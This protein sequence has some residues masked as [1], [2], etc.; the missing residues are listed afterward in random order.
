MKYGLLILFLFVAVFPGRATEAPDAREH[1]TAAERY[2]QQG[3]F[4]SALEEYRLALELGLDGPGV[5]QRLSIL[6]YQQGFV[7]QAIAAMEQAVAFEPETDYLHQQLGLLYFAAAK[8]EQAR[9]EFL[10]SLK[11]NPA[12]AES[13]FYLAHLLGREGKMA[14][15][16]LF[17]RSA[18]QLGHPSRDLSALIEQEDKSSVRNLWQDDQGRLY[19]RKIFVADRSHADQILSRIAAGEPFESFPRDGAPGNNPKRGG[20]A[21]GF[22]PAELHPQIVD[23]LSASGRFGS[24]RLVEL[25]DGI[26]IVQRIAAIDWNTLAKLIEPLPPAGPDSTAVSPSASVPE[27]KKNF[28]VQAGAFK[29]ENYARERIKKLQQL[30]YEA[31]L[32]QATPWILVV[33]A[34]SDLRKDA[35]AVVRQLL[36]QGIDAV[37]VERP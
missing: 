27:V 20:Y 4:F 22:L 31:Y 34:E 25:E 24:P 14:A 13:H 32:Y 3:L 18:R 30:G 16:Q 33:A 9:E 36:R 21:G 5:R 29:D 26:V 12:L 28:L 19:L 35:Q 10:T 37:V 8:L 17:A 1:I 7:D 23:A 15:A 2:V 6:L 11:I